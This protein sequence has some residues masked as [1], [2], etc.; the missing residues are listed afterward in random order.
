MPAPP[1]C[2]GCVTSRY[3]PGDVL[4]RPRYADGGRGPGP[5]RALERELAAVRRG[6]AA[7]NRE[8]EACA[9]LAGGDERLE[10]GGERFRRHTTS[11]ICDLDARVVPVANGTHTHNAVRRV[12]GLRSV[13]QQV[14]KELLER[15]RVA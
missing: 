7:S 13:E 14:Q 2:R 5:G 10:R 11:G 3:E 1:A 9:L 8:A 4:G 12:E 15:C 6:N